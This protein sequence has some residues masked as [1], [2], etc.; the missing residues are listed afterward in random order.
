MGALRVT[1]YGEP[2]LSQ[3]G[4]PITAF[5]ESL[6]A[7][8]ADMFDTMRAE[9]GVGLAAQQIGKAL[10]LFVADFEPNAEEDG[11]ANCLLNGKPTP[12]KLV[13][14]L[15]AANPSLELLDSDW[16]AYE[17]GCLSFP[18]IRGDV[19]RPER[20]RLTYQ[21]TSGDKQILE[22]GGF[23]AR[24]I[25]HEFDHTQGIVFTE[26]MQRDVL[27]ELQ[28]KLK[29]LKRQSRDFLKSQQE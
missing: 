4:E 26:R 16:Y 25:Q 5:D 8:V 7:L 23:L 6:R 20:V 11:F 1:H 15:V 10:A 27:H 29:K 9:F 22:T 24:I 17:E 13:L 14:P 18:E 28:T 2:V 19:E 21:D 3:K 12:L